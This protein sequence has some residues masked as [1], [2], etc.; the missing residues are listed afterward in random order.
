L[1]LNVRNSIIDDLNK[2]EFEEIINNK[3]VTSKEYKLVNAKEP[4]INIAPFSLDFI[5][6]RLSLQISNKQGYMGLELLYPKVISWRGENYEILHDTINFDGKNLYDK[7]VA[8]IKLITKKAKL[9]STFKEYRPD[10]WVSPAA[11]SEIN[12]N[13]YIRSNNLKVN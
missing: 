8:D 3:K 12:K 9:T 6:D 7:I 1:D 13:A 4:V 5:G 11:L 2:V 10:L